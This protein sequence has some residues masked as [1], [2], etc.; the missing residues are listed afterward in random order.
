MLRR[1]SPAAHCLFGVA[2]TINAANYAYFLAQNELLAFPNPFG[3]FQIFNEEMVNLHRGQGLELFWRDTMTVPTEA[4]YI[5]MVSNKTGGLVRLA[6]RLL[7][8]V[9]STSHNVVPLAELIGRIFQIRDDYQNLC[10]DKVS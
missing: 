4:E 3:A 1:G 10:S 2:Q 7:Q 9:S 8:N 6:A 5:K